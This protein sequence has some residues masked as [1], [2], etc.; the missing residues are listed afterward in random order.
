MEPKETD[1]QDVDINIS[2]ERVVPED[3]LLPR[4][5]L[6]LLVKVMIAMSS[7]RFGT[8]ATHGYWTNR[9]ELYW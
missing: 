6:L 5:L 4:Q 2:M 3:V 1:V 7:K 9:G 8:F